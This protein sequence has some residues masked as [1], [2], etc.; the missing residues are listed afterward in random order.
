MVGKEDPAGSLAGPDSDNNGV[1]DDIDRLIQEK[2][3]ATPALR[4]ASEQSARALARFMAATTR[5]QAM[6]AGQDNRRAVEC[7]YRHETQPGMADQAVKEIESLS[8]NT[9]ARFTRYR[10]A[11][12]LV[13]GGHFPDPTGPVC[14]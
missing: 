2:Y 13:A 3:S 12:K 6:A 8:A 10:D 9:Q 1:R 4:K 7:L 5:E 11:N 14:D